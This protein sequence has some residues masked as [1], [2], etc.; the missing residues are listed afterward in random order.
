V[1]KHGLKVLISVEG[2]GFLLYFWGYYLPLHGWCL[3]MCK[4]NSF[5]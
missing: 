2:R 3:G 1:P 5:G 4:L